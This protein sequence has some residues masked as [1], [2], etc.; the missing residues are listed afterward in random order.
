[1]RAMTRPYSFV[2]TNSRPLMQGR[3]T[4]EIG[5]YRITTPSRTCEATSICSGS[6]QDG[7]G[8]EVPKAPAANRG[9]FAS[10]QVVLV[11]FTK[12]RVRKGCQV[13]LFG[14]LSECAFC[15]STERAEV[16]DIYAPTHLNQV[17]SYG[18][19][20]VYGVNW[21]LDAGKKGCTPAS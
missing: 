9:Y 19:V 7:L 2:M 18:T 6:G 16:D 8:Q 1:M 4:P 17:K 12:L 5:Q 11:D 14:I 21:I 10:C 13:G 3:R 20:F 15:G